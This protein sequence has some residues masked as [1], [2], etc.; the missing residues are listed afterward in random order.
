MTYKEWNSKEHQGRT[1]E[2]LLQS[3]EF[4]IFCMINSGILLMITLILS[5]I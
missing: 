1:R 2:S 4:G 5:L 3:S